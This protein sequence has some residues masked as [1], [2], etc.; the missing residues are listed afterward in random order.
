ML[1]GDLGQREK[2]A[3]RTTRKEKNDPIHDINVSSFLA[4]AFI[5]IRCTSHLN[6]DFRLG[7][8]AAIDY[9]PDRLR[10]TAPRRRRS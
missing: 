8:Q 2:P 9:T 4:R 6:Q 3:S 10:W 1:V 7:F 5:L